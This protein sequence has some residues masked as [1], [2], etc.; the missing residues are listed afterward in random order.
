MTDPKRVLILCTGNSARSQMAE[1][2]L[3][4]EAGNQ[5]EVFSAG[6]QPGPVNPLAIEGMREIGIDISGH[7][8]KS[9][10]EFIGQE[11]DYLITVCDTAKESCPVFPRKAKRIHWSFE[12]PAATQG[13][14]A[15]RLAVFRRVRDEIRKRLH[16][17]FF[18]SQPSQTAPSTAACSE[19]RGGVLPFL[20]D[21]GVNVPPEHRVRHAHKAPRLHEPDARRLMRGL[22][23]ARDHVRVDRVGQEM[24]H[25]APLGDDAIDGLDL[26]LGVAAR[27]GC[28]CNSSTSVHEGRFKC[29]GAHGSSNESED[30]TGC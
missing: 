19:R 2:I 5:F 18:S 6:T 29:H 8:S 23:Q 26:P 21:Q 11:F 4:Y 7:R 27:R 25:V 17:A 28:G 16:A 30:R 15:A 3:R 10:E 22:K 14:E 20:R 12:D 13:D 1:G 9:V 24:P